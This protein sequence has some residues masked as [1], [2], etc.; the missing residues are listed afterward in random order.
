LIS[1]F[2]AKEEDKKKGFD[3]QS[4]G[5]Y[6]HVRKTSLNGFSLYV[7]NILFKDG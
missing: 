6:L 3:F 5:L 7:N 4:D 2:K 1:T